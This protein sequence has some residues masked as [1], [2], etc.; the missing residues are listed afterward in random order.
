MVI[1]NKKNK[2]SFKLI[3]IAGNNIVIEDNITKE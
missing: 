2:K 3:Y 1:N